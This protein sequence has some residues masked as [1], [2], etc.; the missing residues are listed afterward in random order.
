MVK[1]SNSL[2]ELTGK[3]IIYILFMGFISFLKTQQIEKQMVSHFKKLVKS[4]LHDLTTPHPMNFDNC[5]VRI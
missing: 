1:R 4:L 5:L 3:A 2:E